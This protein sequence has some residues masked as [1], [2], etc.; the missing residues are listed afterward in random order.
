MKLPSASTTFCRA[1]GCSSPSFARPS[2]SGLSST[3]AKPT[4][5]FASIF[6]MT[7]P[8][9][10]TRSLRTIGGEFELL[11]EEGDFLACCVVVTVD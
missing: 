11:Q 2:S 4:S 8:T 1:R 10:V 5:R 6:S 3:T 7:V 9:W